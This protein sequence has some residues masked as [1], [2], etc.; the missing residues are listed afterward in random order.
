MVFSSS[1][2]SSSE[3][4]PTR[5]RSPQRLRVL[6]IFDSSSDDESDNT[7]NKETIKQNHPESQDTLLATQSQAPLISKQQTP[8][9]NR[10]RN[11]G[12]RNH[13]GI[14]SVIQARDTPGSIAMESMTQASFINTK[15]EAI[16]VE[17]DQEEKRTKGAARVSL[18]PEKPNLLLS[19]VPRSTK[20]TTQTMSALEAIGVR[21]LENDSAH[22]LIKSKR[23][24]LESISQVM[25]MSVEA[26]KAYEESKERTASKIARQETNAGAAKNPKD[27]AAIQRKPLPSVLDEGDILSPKPNTSRRRNSVALLAVDDDDDDIVPPKTNKSKRK[28]LAVDDDDIVPPTTNKSKRRNRVLEVE[29]IKPPNPKKPKTNEKLEQ[30]ERADEG[31]AKPKAKK[32]PKNTATKKASSE[33]PKTA[34][35]TKRMT[36]AGDSKASSPTVQTR[37][38]PRGKEGKKKVKNEANTK[39][40]V[41][42]SAKNSPENKEK[43]ASKVA[44]AIEPA[45]KSPAPAPTKSKTKNRVGVESVEN[46]PENKMNVKTKVAEANERAIKRA[47]PSPVPLKPK[48]KKRTFQDQV[49]AEMFFSCKPYT[50][51]T[52]SQALQTTEA[53]LNY[54]MLTLLDKQI[55]L[56]KEFSSSGS[57]R[58][59]ELY[60]ANQDSKAK[61]IQGLLVSPQEMGA[62]EKELQS[63]QREHAELQKQMAILTQELSNEE[64]D[65]QVQD[66][67]ANVAALKMSILEIHTRIKATKFQ[68]PKKGIRPAAKERCPRR[69][70]IRINN[71][72]DEWKQR[73]TKCMDFVEQVADGMDKKPKD[74]IKLLELETD[75]MEGVVIPGKHDIE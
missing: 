15:L 11:Y 49:L 52:L 72:R 75:E 33:V 38:S 40:V 24:K 1:S 71:M 66:M 59:K 46:A 41:V 18:S 19:K 30:A 21:D 58:S 12:G 53:A 60:W 5:R 9:A 73:K 74:V 23:E 28:S 42:E 39:I 32:S 35:N 6:E 69:M 61:E 56:K 16:T 37:T 10:K 70:K 20:S 4:I 64:V 45:S 17:K 8:K 25:N 7:M 67:E 36:P 55:V 68:P 57:G 44:E 29:D 31:S 63:V 27:E 62:T 54:V 51:K 43:I 65:R 34:K 47:I 14:P 48:T 13:D 22:N 50:I 2:S 3:E 26:V